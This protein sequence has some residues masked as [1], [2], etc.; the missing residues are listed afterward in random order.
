MESTSKRMSVYDLQEIVPELKLQFGATKMTQLI[1]PDSPH[2]YSKDGYSELLGI[3]RQTQQSYGQELSS[4]ESIR[5]VDAKFA[6]IKTLA[7]TIR[8]QPKA[9]ES[10]RL[11]NTT[12][13][14]QSALHTE[15]PQFIKSL[16]SLVTEDAN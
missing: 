5:F 4:P 10:P 8:I 15:I 12:S 1:Q 9:E 13:R 14:S 11:I 16:G 3:M 7:E 2:H 6:A